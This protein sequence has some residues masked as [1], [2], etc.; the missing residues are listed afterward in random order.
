V[1][2]TNKTKR[3]GV[4]LLGQSGIRL[5]LDNVVVYVDPYLT[6]YVA[7][8]EGE[9]DLRRLVP[10]PFQPIEVTDADFVLVTHIH[11][12]HCD[13][14]TL[15]PIAEAS[16]SAKF[17][18][19]NECRIFLEAQGLPAERIVLA[20]ERQIE[21]ARGVHLVAVP[22]AH[23]TIDTDSEGHLKYVGYVLKCNE[24]TYYHAGD[25][26]PAELLIKAV[27][28]KGPI[29]VAF[30]PVNERNYYRDRRGIIGNMSIR[31]AFQLGQDIG[32]KHVIPIHW[33][34]FA[35]NSVY[36]EEIQLV[37]ELMQPAIQLHMNAESLQE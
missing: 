23:P 20:P 18:C 36:P 19:P 21:L 15:L 28:E 1:N 27:L 24:R 12:D 3:T 7:E 30:L 22:A 13:P 33:D 14:T 8:V 5:Q 32:A 34:M 2:S 26:S 29:D 17:V 31:E 11:M 6:D 9:P 35:P 4:R 16:R 10:P 25:T 37:Y